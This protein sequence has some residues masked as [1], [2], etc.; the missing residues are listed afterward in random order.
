[1]K[2]MSPSTARSCAATWSRKAVHVRG[3]LYS[4]N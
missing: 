4:V 2:L 1:L 3:L